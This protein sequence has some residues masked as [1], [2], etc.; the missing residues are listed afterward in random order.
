MV[1]L[2]LVAHISLSLSTIGFDCKVFL[3]FFSF[4]FLFFFFGSPF[5]YPLAGRGYS[6][7]HVKGFCIQWGL[8]LLVSALLGE[9]HLIHNFI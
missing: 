6:N 9:E 2:S 3:P 8:G 1:R 7:P 4:V 5:V